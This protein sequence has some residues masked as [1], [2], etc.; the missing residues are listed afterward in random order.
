M[1]YENAIYHYLGPFH[2]YWSKILL[3]FRSDRKVQRKKE[4]SIIMDTPLLIDT[5]DGVVDHKGRP[6]LR[7]NTGGWRSAY[8]IIG[9]NTPLIIC[10]EW[11]CDFCLS[12][13]VIYMNRCGSG[14]EVRVLWDK[15]EPDNVFDWTAGSVN[16]HCGGE[17]EH[18]VRHCHVASSFGCSRGWFFSG[19][20]PHHCHCFSYLHPRMCQLPFISTLCFALN[21]LWHH[22]INVLYV[23]HQLIL[24]CPWIYL[25]N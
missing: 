17:R 16:G 8:F 6:V 9:N 24:L 5:V 19:S 12:I 18:V 4:R 15:L 7:S 2:H 13:S 25:F 1:M 21:S 11:E 20:L 3:Q 23:H 22:P 10:W 14:W